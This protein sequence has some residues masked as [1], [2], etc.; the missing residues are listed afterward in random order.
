MLNI[1]CVNL[2]GDP[3]WGP[4]F[5]L[6]VRPP[7]K[8]IGRISQLSSLQVAHSSFK[9]SPTFSWK[10]LGNGLVFFKGTSPNGIGL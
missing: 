8:M 9:S 4:G 10:E 3:F 1:H 7:D 5:K 6:S 2:G